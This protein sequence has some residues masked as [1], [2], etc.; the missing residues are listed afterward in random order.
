A[1]LVWALIGVLASGAG[2]V[3]LDPAYPA[4]RTAA[5][6]AVS[7]PRAL[8]TI[9]A[10]GPLPREVADALESGACRVDLSEVPPSPTTRPAVT[11]GP[12]DPAYIAFTSGSTGG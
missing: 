2:F 5:Y 12:D 8:V 3:V 1:A 10:A 11:V 4:A 7:R 9:P 6:V